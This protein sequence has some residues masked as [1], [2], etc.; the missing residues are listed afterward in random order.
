M[1]DLGIEDQQTLINTGIQTGRDLSAPQSTCVN[2]ANWISTF[3]QVDDT[4]LQESEQKGYRQKITVF[5][6]LGLFF[7]GLPVFGI[8]GRVVVA[9]TLTL[10][11][12]LIKYHNFP[13]EQPL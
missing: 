12:S 10:S 11:F 5:L 8:L 7:I 4:A 1:T 9:I 2:P 13:M 3:S 6:L